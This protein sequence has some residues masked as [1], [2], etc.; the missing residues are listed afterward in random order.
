MLTQIYIAIWCHWVKI[1]LSGWRDLARSYDSV[2]RSR[3]ISSAILKKKKHRKTL[4]QNMRITH[5][6]RV[7]SYCQN[8]DYWWSIRCRRIRLPVDQV[9]LPLDQVRLPFDQVRL[10]LDR[11]RLPLY[12]VRLPLDQVRLPVEQVRLP[13]DQVQRPYGQR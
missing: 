5:W 9:R 2:V 3:E 13:L 11:V 6:K 4:L 10:P 8:W 12:Q 7:Q 1:I